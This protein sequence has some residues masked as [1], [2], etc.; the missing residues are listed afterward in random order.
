MLHLSRA[1][2]AAERTVSIKHT[3]VRGKGLHVRRDKRVWQVDQL[4]VKLA[5][6]W[7]RFVSVDCCSCYLARTK[8]FDKRIVFDLV[9][10]SSAC[11]LAQE[12]R[13]R[14]ARPP[15]AVFISI[16]DGFI[17]SNCRDE[18]MFFV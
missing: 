18:I 5:R 9:R 12:G 4:A 13:A 14:L 11:R 7:F 2:A 3:Y 1:S 10:E 17:V 8:R 6:R 16:A 15:R